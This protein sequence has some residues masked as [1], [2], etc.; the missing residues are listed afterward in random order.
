MS[1][2]KKSLSKQGAALSVTRQSFSGP[3]PPPQI[4]AQYDQIVPGA[5][6]RILKMAETQEVHRHG[7]EKKVIDSGISNSQRGM[8]FGFLIGMT[9]IVSGAVV[10]GMNGVAAVAG[11]AVISTGGLVSLVGVFV[12]GAKIR[13]E[14]REEKKN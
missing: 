4:L 1:K 6:E 9:A 8:I 7:I 11:G 12:Y 10:A 3:I 2:K 13:K 5:A 14:E